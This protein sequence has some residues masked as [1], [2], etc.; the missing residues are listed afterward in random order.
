MDRA[1]EWLQWITTEMFGLMHNFETDNFDSRRYVG[2]DPRSFPFQ[3]HAS[4]FSFLR[5]NVA[6]FMAARDL[7]ADE[8]SKDLFDR[9]ILFRLL[10]HLHVRLPFNL[11]KNRNYSDVVE[12]W[13]VADTDETSVIGTLSIYVVPVQDDAISIKCVDGNIAASLLFRQYYFERAGVKIAPEVADCVLDVGACFGDT[14]LFFAH[15]VGESG[16]VHT[17]DPMPKHCEIIRENL[18]MNV[19]LAKRI[20]LHPYGLSDAISEVQP[21]RGG[22]DPGARVGD[23]LPT[24]TLD[25][26]NLTHVDFIKMDI[27]GSELAALKGGEKL[28]RQSRPK[29][30]ISLYHRPEDFFTI[31]LWLDSLGCGYRFHLDHYSIHHEETVLYA[32]VADTERSP[33]PGIGLPAK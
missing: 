31:P 30:A 28:I 22:I 11:P 15:D 27:E 6:R 32:A 20:T 33:E 1:E 17:F 21:L 23:D 14:A 18:G 13:H 9:L 19:P 24:R 2:V 25:S 7:L 16:R 5:N 8:E 10:G 3:R 12:P 26:L 29:L 4:Y